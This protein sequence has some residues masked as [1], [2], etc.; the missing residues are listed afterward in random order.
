MLPVVG[1]TLAFALSAIST[2]ILRTVSSEWGLLDKPDGGHK[3]HT[4]AVPLMGGYLD[5]YVN[6]V[7]ILMRYGGITGAFFVSTCIVGTDR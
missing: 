6:A 5:N 1:I 2:R 4:E 7:L 3:R